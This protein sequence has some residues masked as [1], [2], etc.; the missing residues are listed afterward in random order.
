MFKKGDCSKDLDEIEEKLSDGRIKK[1][2]KG[3]FLG[4]VF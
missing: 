3:R 4:K 1:Y 2:I